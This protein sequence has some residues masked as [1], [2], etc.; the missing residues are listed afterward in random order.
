MME[1]F[2]SEP[3]SQDNLAA[4][5]IEESLTSILS[6][7]T[8]S[9]EQPCVRLKRRPSKDVVFIDNNSR[10]LKA[11]GEESFKTYTWPGRTIVQT[12]KFSRVQLHLINRQCPISLIIPLT[13]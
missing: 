6:S 8:V 11:N 10:A 7:L 1:F 13:I 12:W 5:F 4:L 2:D 3:S 9:G